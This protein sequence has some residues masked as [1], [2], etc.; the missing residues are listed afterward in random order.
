MTRV[1]VG[2]LAVVGL[3]LVGAGVL[4]AFAVGLP[5]LGLNPYGRNPLDETLRGLGTAATLYAVGAALLAIAFRWLR[6]HRGPLNV[7]G[8]SFAG[9][10][11]LG[12]TGLMA[13][14][15]NWTGVAMLLILVIGI[16]VPIALGG[17]PWTSQL[18]RRARS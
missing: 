13:I 14:L 6:D 8:F 16:A 18:S 17:G 12:L 3:L 2:A 5:A 15:R 4:V 10:M 1:A 7:W 11:S 9:I